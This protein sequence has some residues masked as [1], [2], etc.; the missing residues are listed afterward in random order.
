MTSPSEDTLY[1]GSW[2]RPLIPISFRTFVALGP[3]IFI[4]GCDNPC[5]GLCLLVVVWFH[6]THSLVFAMTMMMTMMMRQIQAFRSL[7]AAPLVARTLSTTAVSSRAGGG[8]CPVTGSAA[9]NT[10]V[11]GGHP[12]LQKIPKLPLLGSSVS[13]YSGIPPMDDSK[14][15]DFWPRLQKDFGDFYS[16]GILGL[17][18]GLFQEIHVLSDPKEYMKIVRKEGKFPSS[19]I[20][21]QWALRE[22]LEQANVGRA[23]DLFS[24][25]Q[26][27]KTIRLFFQT[28]L[29]SPQSAAQYVPNIQRAAEIS[30]QAAPMYENDIKTF[31]DRAAFDMF[32][33]VMMGQ[34]TGISDPENPNADPEDIEF[35]QNVATALALNNQ[36]TKSLSAV[37]LKKAFG[38]ETEILKEMKTA[39]SRAFSHSRKRIEEFVERR[40]RGELTEG[41]KFSYLNMALERQKQQDELSEH[42]VQGLCM[43]FLGASVDTTSGYITWPLL[44]TALDHDIQVR[45]RN[46]LKDHLVDGKIT[47]EAIRPKN[48]PYLHATFREA[49]RLNSTSPITAF[50][51]VPEDIVVHGQTFPAGTAFAFDGFSKGK[52]LVEDPDTFIPDRW[53]PDAV[54]ARKG[55]PAEIL[56]HPLYSGP[57]SQGARRCPG[58]R[59][60]HNESLALMAQLVYDWDMSA[61]EVASY[62][63]VPYHLSTLNV[64]KMPKIHFEAAQK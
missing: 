47:P 48:A 54:E 58:S 62:Q 5:V 12:K 8:A 16:I 1:P 24:H 18:V 63:E 49:H 31:L 53:L 9:A 25:G 21:L 60:A 38:Y 61:P 52:T 55:T 46:E 35:A 28:D 57:F 15:Y 56:D 7:R 39:W 17:G 19:V 22:A 26:E 13:L 40:E 32:N 3:S 23:M 33:M 2:V 44:H 42:D 11:D 43:G 27:W 37:I 14:T 41:E 36:I 10:A 29:F 45:I 6:F 51:Y 50:K 59:V 34:M 20:E 4:P 30:S 64:P